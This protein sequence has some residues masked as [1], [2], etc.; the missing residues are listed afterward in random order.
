MIH[1]THSE[2][3]PTT[4]EKSEAERIADGKES[5]F[6]GFHEVG[7]ATWGRRRMIGSE[8]TTDHFHGM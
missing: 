5:R 4:P 7:K 3:A 6:Q 2:P 1:K 8:F